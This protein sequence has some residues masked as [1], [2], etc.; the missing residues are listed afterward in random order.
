MA[1]A[2]FVQHGDSIDHTPVADVAPGEV[3]VQGELVGIAKT[4][5]AAGVLGA[6]A[7]VGV[8]DVPKATGVTTAITAG[9][10]VYWDAGNSVATTDD[11]TGNNKLLGKTIAAAADDD[12]TVRVRLSQ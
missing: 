3:V 8:F 1:T 12:A 9:A 6:I 10:K 5:I 2:T 4:A 11:D 7:V